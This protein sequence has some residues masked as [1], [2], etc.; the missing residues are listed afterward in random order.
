MNKEFFFYNCCLEGRQ[1]ELGETGF[2][3][4]KDA[5]GTGD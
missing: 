5:T 3:A 4:A 1:L 2:L